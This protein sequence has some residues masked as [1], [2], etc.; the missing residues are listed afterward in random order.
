MHPKIGAGFFTFEI[1][2][3]QR[4]VQFRVVLVA[5]E[6]AA[7]VSWKL[8]AK[9]SPGGVLPEPANERRR[10]GLEFVLCEAPVA[11]R[12]GLNID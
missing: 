1:L 9:A 4:A 10:E 2:V 3:L 11:G 12:S 6:H 8:R 7:E 5:H